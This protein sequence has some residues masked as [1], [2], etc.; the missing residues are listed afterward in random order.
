MP[1]RDDFSIVLV[2]R[3]QHRDDQGSTVGSASCTTCTRPYTSEADM[4]SL[5]TSL[6]IMTR[7][8]AFEDDTDDNDVDKAEQRL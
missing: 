6:A 4:N 7:G 3:C 8:M 5:I 2:D 1:V